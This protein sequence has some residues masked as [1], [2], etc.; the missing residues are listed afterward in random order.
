MMS[1]SIIRLTKDQSQ[2][3]V[4]LRTIS[5]HVKELVF[6]EKI[7][8]SA[9]KS[10]F[11]LLNEHNLTVMG[12]FTAY[13]TIYRQFENDPFRLQ[14]S[15]DGSEYTEPDSPEASYTITF[16]AAAGGR[17]EGQTEQIVDDYIDLE[18]PAPA[19]DENYSFEG[20]S[21]E[22]PKDGEV[23][24]NKVFTACFVYV[25][26]LKEVQSRKIDEL[27]R[28]CNAS[29]LS[30]VSVDIDGTAERFSYTMEDQRNIDDLFHLAAATKLAQPYHCDGGDCRLYSTEQILEIYR[31]EQINK[32]HHT[33]Y[34]NQLKAMVSA[35]ETKE[36]V[37]AAVYGMGLT[38]KY[39]DTYNEMMAQAN[40]ILLTV[41]AQNKPAEA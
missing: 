41:I 13:T 4:E 24:E 40:L 25:P 11:E 38:G 16:T 33:T 26:T 5:E 3:E 39:S 10:G 9:A 32:I 29:I 30:G 23:T 14:L 28:I 17:L 27:N 6:A 22:L 18:L 37:E 36:E 2:H 34:F 15:D 7:L 12:D 21:P 19:A 35:M 1:K 8:L 20:W 31:A